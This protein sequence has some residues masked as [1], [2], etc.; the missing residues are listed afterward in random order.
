MPALSFKRE[1]IQ[2]LLTGSKT[3]TTRRPRIGRRKAP[4]IK[5]G[6]NVHVYVEQ[7]RPISEKPVYPTTK[8]GRTLIYQK[9][10]DGRYP[11]PVEDTISYTD[12]GS[13]YAH[14]LGI[15][16]VTRILTLHPCD[17]THDEKQEWAWAD[18]FSDFDTGD[19]WFVKHHTDYAWTE[20]A[21][22][23]IQ[24]SGWEKRYYEPR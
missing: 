12:L 22:D 8:N 5:E 10:L 13:Y 4:R 11:S 14:F 1:W 23:V 19:K 3:Q 21:W 7:R 18:G 15:V 16:E 6:D 24:W 20:Q 9:I 17:L 2:A